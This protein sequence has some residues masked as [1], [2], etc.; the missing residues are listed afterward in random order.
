M[1]CDQACRYIT[2]ISLPDSNENFMGIIDIGYNLIVELESEALVST[3]CPNYL[4]IL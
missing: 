1:S 2:S 3:Y 4:L